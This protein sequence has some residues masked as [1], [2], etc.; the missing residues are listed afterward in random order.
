MWYGVRV[1]KWKTLVAHPLFP[2]VYGKLLA[3]QSPY[4]IVAWLR[5][6]IPYDADGQDPWAR[7]TDSS[8]ARRLYR[9]KRMLPEGAVL[10]RSY[11]DEKFR[12]LGAGIEV[13]EELDSLI[14]YQKERVASFAE[15]EQAFPI[16]VEQQRKEI[17]T[18]ADLLRQRR[19]AAAA[20]GL[21]P[22]AANPY[23]SSLTQVN[24]AVGSG[25][26]PEMGDAR[27]VVSSF[28]D[29]HPEAIPGVM[30]YLDAADRLVDANEPKLLEAD[31]HSER[32]GSNGKGPPP[33][34]FDDERP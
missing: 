1:S 29:V 10:A 18:L 17:L 2:H 23:V 27:V 33:E 20:M 24:V 8:L 25:R 12:R 28:L 4:M 11:L 7:V 16:L 9:F 21:M 15:R 6:Q 5:A 31:L 32:N 14:R 30:E 19:E 34:V 3:G 13:L 26:V 22:G